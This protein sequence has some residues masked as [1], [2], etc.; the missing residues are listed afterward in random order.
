MDE[1]TAIALPCQVPGCGMVWV[2]EADENDDVGRHPL[3]ASLT[4]IAA[5]LHDA[6]DAH[7][8]E[9][10]ALRCERMALSLG[11]PRH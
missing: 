7:D 5:H 2:L 11:R 6:H 10:A 8:A 9:A 1:A 4:D 3:V